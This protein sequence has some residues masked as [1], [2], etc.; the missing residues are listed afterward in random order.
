MTATALIGALLALLPA[1][2][3]KTDRDE[4]IERLERQLADAN[5]DL[6]VQKLI[7]AH[8]KDEAKRIAIQSRQEREVLQM[9][10][11]GLERERVQNRF[12]D[13]YQQAQQYQA[14]ANQQA[15]QQAQVAQY[16]GVGLLGA[17]QGWADRQGFCNC[18]PSRSQVWAAN[19][20]D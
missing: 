17:Q 20:G 8:W 7:A 13:G 4:K 10:I 15:A 9:R 6:H 1:A 11:V 16:S 5:R 19:Q 18:V 14:L 3:P 2:R 12:L